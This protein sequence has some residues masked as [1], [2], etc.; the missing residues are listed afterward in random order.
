MATQ[1]PLT[2]PL[3]MV[4]QIGEQ[5][6]QTVQSVQTSMA[7]AVSQT[8]DSLISGAPALPGVPGAAAK[9]GLPSPAS[10][11]PANIQQVLGQVENLIVPPGL[12]KPTQVMGGITPPAVTPPATQP[13]QTPTQQGSTAVGYRKVLERRGI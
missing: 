1:N 7:Q 5:S 4:K 13:A 3:S 8:L 10:L 9:G 11:M 12:P 6:V 2:A